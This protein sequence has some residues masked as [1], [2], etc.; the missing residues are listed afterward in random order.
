MA[1]KIRML[2]EDEE[3]LDCKSAA[4]G[5]ISGYREGGEE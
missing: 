1:R 3:G 5:G 2:R 4:E